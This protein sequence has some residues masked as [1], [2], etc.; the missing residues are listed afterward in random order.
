MNRKYFL[1]A[2]VLSVLLSL[3]GDSFTFGNDRL[4]FQDDALTA[5]IDKLFAQ[6]DKPDSPGAMLA[7][8]KDGK[9]IYKRGYGMADLEHNIPISAAT[10]FNIAS[11]SK[12]FTAMSIL[13]LVRQGKIS[14]DDDLQKYVPDIPKYDSPV[15]I[16]QLIHHTSG[17]RDYLGLMSLAGLRQEDYYDNDDIIELMERQKNLNFKPGSEYLYSNTGYV[18]LSMVV[19]KVSGKS[20]RDFAKENIFKPLGMKNTQIRDDHTAI[21]PNRAIG[22]SPV[23]GGMFQIKVQDVDVV[24]DGNLYTTVDDLFLWDQNFY[25]NILNAQD[26]ELISQMLAPFTL[27]SGKDTGSASGLHVGQYKGLKF[28]SHPGSMPGYRSQM[29]RFP[30]ER[31]SVI[32]LANASDLNAAKLADQVADIFLADKL[33]PVEAENRLPTVLPSQFIKLS[34]QELAANNGSYMDPLTN[35]FWQVSSADGIL[36]AATTKG[37]FKFAALSRN[38]FRST[39]VNPARE[40]IFETS[41]NKSALMLVK[42]DGRQPA[43][44][45]GAKPAIL[46]ADQLAEYAGEY[47]SDELQATYK[48]V[49]EE[50][51][52]FYRLGYGRVGNNFRSKGPIFLPTIKDRFNAGG[53]SFHFIRNGQDRITEFTLSIGRVKDLRFVKTPPTS[54]PRAQP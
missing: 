24:G 21:V 43:T 8:I 25:N 37:N 50:G 19:Q 29:I 7:V 17:I 28:V 39:N 47:Y 16:R 26:K 18:L 45:E 27:T 34:E 30:D 40:L 4:S 14:L 20:L 54:V 49:L 3:A 42:T 36:I 46:S 9:V 10:V 35:D 13:M 11:T 33:K 31:F 1:A 23:K 41:A 6:W 22:Y 52:L 32:C 48:V 53:V 38:H 5:K 12:Q 15:T 44:F 51:K 2:L